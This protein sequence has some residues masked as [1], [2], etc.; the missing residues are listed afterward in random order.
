MEHSTNA[1]K[2]NAN[3]RPAALGQFPAKRDE[4]RFDIAPCN[5]GPFRRFENPFERLAVFAGHFKEMIS[6]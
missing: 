1:P 2:R 5:I 6:E 3:A 4:K